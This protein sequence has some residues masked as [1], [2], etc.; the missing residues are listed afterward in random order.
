MQELLVVNHEGAAHRPH[1]C[2]AVWAA[3]SWLSARAQL[4]AAGLPVEEKQELQG[5]LVPKQRH[6]QVRLVIVYTQC[7]T[8]VK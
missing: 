7:T 4:P 2:V 6:V 1:T 8:R 3:C 5:N